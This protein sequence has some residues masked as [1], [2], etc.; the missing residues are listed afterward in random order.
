MLH[1]NQTRFTAWSYM[2]SQQSVGKKTAKSELAI[3]HVWKHWKCITW[4]IWLAVRNN[5]TSVFMETYFIKFHQKIA[6][7]EFH[8]S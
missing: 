2:T 6:F 5:F 1:D 7:D 4:P 8:V 3:S